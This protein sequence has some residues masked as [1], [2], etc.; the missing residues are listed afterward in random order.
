VEALN[1]RAKKVSPDPA[2]HTGPGR[3]VR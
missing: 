1:L 3:P 2:E